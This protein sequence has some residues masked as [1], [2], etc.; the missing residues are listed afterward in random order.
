MKGDASFSVATRILVPLIVGFVASASAVFAGTWYLGE[1]LGA[2][3]IQVVL[4]M[5]LLTL[6][7]AEVTYPRMRVTLFRRQT[8]KPLVGVL[9]PMIGGFIWGLDTGTVVSTFRA[10]AASLA[11]LLL[12]AVG[13]APAWSGL[14]YALAFCIPLAAAVIMTS[15]LRQHS[16]LGADTQVVIERLLNRAPRVRHIVAATIS[17]AILIA[18]VG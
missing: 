5:L 7:L 6:L 9:P 13:W 15:P 4:P 8:P 18:L 3:R 12:V 1:A 2:D 16:A 17:A 10:S 11:G 14:I